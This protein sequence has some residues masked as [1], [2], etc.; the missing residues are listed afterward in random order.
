M[1]QE[2]NNVPKPKLIAFDLGKFEFLKTI[3]YSDLNNFERDIFYFDWCLAAI[4][5]HLPFPS[6]FRISPVNMC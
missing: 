6:L 1:D 4:A 5:E 2:N 3:I